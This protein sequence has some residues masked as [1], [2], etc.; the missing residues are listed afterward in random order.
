[1]PSNQVN[2]NPYNVPICIIMNLSQNNYYDAILDYIDIM[3]A[4]AR[5]LLFN[6]YH[7]PRENLLNRSGD[8]TPQGDYVTPYKVMGTTLSIMYWS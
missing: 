1:M 5:Y 8:V 2:S 3:S 4:V 6:S 7:I